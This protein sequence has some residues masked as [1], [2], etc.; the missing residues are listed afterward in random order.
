MYAHT[1]S[2]DSLPVIFAPMT[3]RDVPDVDQLEQRCFPTPWSAAT[4]RHELRHN[5]QSHYWVVRPR[6][7]VLQS[8]GTNIPS[9][10]GYGGYWFVVDEAHIV[11]IATH[12][13]WRRRKLGTWLLIN[14]LDEA[15]NAGAI[16]ATL[17]VRVSNIAAKTLYERLGFIE[18]G[19]RKEYYPRTEPMGRGEDAI[20]MTLFGLEL[21]NVWQ[22][23]QRERNA[24]TFTL[25]D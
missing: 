24:I 25:A 10:L 4:Y 16:Q 21:D 14:M 17:E 7:E 5:P 23:L 22:A 8:E 15:R 1:V 20:L 12:P 2:N 6:P 19:Y 9:L 3:L 13:A 11:T 18:V